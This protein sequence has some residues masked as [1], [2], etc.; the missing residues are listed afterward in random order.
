MSSTKDHHLKTKGCRL[1]DIG[2]T[3]EITFFGMSEKELS[4][5]NIDNVP[6][7]VAESA[8]TA[9]NFTSRKTMR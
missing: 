2:G 3:H 6:Q 8:L 1:D 7:D 5:P 9:I 4:R